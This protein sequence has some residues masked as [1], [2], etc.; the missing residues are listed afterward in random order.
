[1]RYNFFD[2]EER[3]CFDLYL[4][5]NDTSV[6]HYD[7]YVFLKKKKDS[8]SCSQTLIIL[9]LVFFIIYISI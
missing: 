9:I 4:K 5:K 1:M 7:S 2:Y 6:N 3:N 8:D